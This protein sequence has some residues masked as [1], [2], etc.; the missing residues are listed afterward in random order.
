[1][2]KVIQIYMLTF[3]FNSGMSHSLQCKDVVE[4]NKDKNDK[5]V[6]SYSQHPSCGD[7][8]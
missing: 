2:K 3:I 5:K 4:L 1:M 7:D 8:S 6:W